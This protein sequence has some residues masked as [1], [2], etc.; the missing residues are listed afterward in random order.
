MKI[1][2]EDFCLIPQI[3]RNGIYEVEDWGIT[4]YYL[5][6]KFHRED[7]PAIKFNN[8]TKEWYINGKYSRLDG[9]AREFSSI[10]KEYWIEGKH[11]STKEDFESAAYLYNN[12]LQDYL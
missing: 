10:D 12:G 6:G 4:Y 8:G 3:Q 2:K 9:P 11:Y 1:S 5:N 7:G